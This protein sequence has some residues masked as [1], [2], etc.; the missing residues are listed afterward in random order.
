MN[1]DPMNYR[2]VPLVIEQTN[3][4]ERAYDIYSRL[5][6]ERIVFIGS[7]INDFVANV[8]VAQ[9]LFLQAEDP[10]KDISIYINSRG[11]EI[12][13]GLAI[14]DTMQHVKPAISTMC[15]GL[16]ASMAAVLLAGGEKDKRFMLPNAKAM[17]HQ[18]WGGVQGQAT[19]IQ[20]HA[21]EILRTRKILNE[22]LAQHTGQS[23][24]VIERDTERDFY[25][26]AE[27]AQKYGL[28]DQIL[29]SGPVTSK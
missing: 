1:L 16:A 10:E 23:Y 2:E 29:T 6:K 8:V 20:I 24:D 11:G 27:E 19:D 7:D 21:K 15:V 12:T 26:S 5:L 13:A 18:P 3:R 4:G 9:L 28:V 17:I 14:Y 25:M 22:I